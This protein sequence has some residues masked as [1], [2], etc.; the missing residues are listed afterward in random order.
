VFLSG[1]MCPFPLILNVAM[2]PK[3]YAYIELRQINKA[4]VLIF[5]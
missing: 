1:A 3:L 4:Q 2:F 5:Y